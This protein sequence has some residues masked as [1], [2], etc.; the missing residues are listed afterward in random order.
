MSVRVFIVDYLIGILE[1]LRPSEE[2]IGNV[3]ELP[4]NR[5]YTAG[6]EK[7]L[8]A[9]GVIIPCEYCGR[10]SIGPPRRIGGSMSYTCSSECSR[11]LEKRRRELVP[12]DYLE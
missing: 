6:T 9:T 4:V 5:D 2:P 11:L 8:V 10:R 3:Y 7:M 12:G 1:S